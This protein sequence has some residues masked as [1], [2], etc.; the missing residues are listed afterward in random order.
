MKKSFKK[1]YVELSLSIFSFFAL[2]GFS[3]A[4]FNPLGVRAI[5]EN[6]FPLLDFLKSLNPVIL[7]L[8]IFFNNSWKAFIVIFTGVFFGITPFLFLAVNGFLVGLVCAVQIE[9]GPLW[10]VAGLAPHGIFELAGVFVACGYG[11][12][13]GRKMFEYV[14]WRRPMTGALGQALRGFWKTVAP[15]LALAAAIEVF[16]TPSIMK[17]V[18]K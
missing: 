2:L 12:W 17:L 8:F 14:F 16:F 10:L 7:A 4:L 13:L 6:L 18:G 15:L 9:K 5:L 11:F 3:A 1:P